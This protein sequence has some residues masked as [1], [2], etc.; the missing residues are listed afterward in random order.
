M[1]ILSLKEIADLPLCSV[2]SNALH[3]PDYRT[4]QGEGRLPRLWDFNCAFARQGDDRAAPTPTDLV[5]HMAIRTASWFPEIGSDVDPY[6]DPTFRKAWAESARRMGIE[7]QSIMTPR[8]EPV[9]ESLKFR[10]AVWLDGTLGWE[11]GKLP[12]LLETGTVYQS[13]LTP[14]L[15]HWYTHGHPPLV[16]IMQ[17]LLRLY[18]QGLHG[19]RPT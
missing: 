7:G 9:V 10:Y 11:A 2:G 13:G 16:G 5:R 1:T 3:N 8:T 14:L 6:I 18:L 12:D 4:G 17:E 15:K 19:F